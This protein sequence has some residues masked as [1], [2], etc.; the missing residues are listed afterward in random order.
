MTRNTA[1]FI[2]L[3]I[4]FFIT[5]AFSEEAPATGGV[6]AASGTFSL[7]GKKISIEDAVKL[8]LQNNKDLLDARYDAKMADSQYQK[9][10]SK[11][12]I[13]LGAQGELTYQKYPDLLSPQTG[14]SQTVTDGTVSIAKNFSTGTTLAGGMKQSMTQTDYT[15]NPLHLPVLSSTGVDSGNYVPYSLGYDKYFQP[16]MFVQVQQELLKNSFGYSDRQQEKILQN[17][18]KLQRRAQLARVSGLVA[19]A[20][21]DIWNV[22][23]KKTAL[24]NSSV[25]LKETKKVRDIVAAN[26]RLGISETFDL[27]LYNAMY[28]GSEARYAFAEQ[29][30]RD[31][32]RKLYRT[33]NVEADDSKQ[34]VT[35][36]LT[37][38]STLQDISV[39]AALKA[40]YAKRVDY[41][42]ALMEEENSKMDLGIA[43][44]GELPSLTAGASATYYSYEEKFGKA[45][46]NMLSLKTPNYG[47]N[48]KMSYPLFDT[49]T[50]VTV[51]DAEYK[52]QQSK[53]RLDKIRRAVKDDII[54]KAEQV[55][56]VFTGYQKAKLAREES[57]RYFYSIQNYLRM[58]KVTSAV[59]KNA[60]DSLTS[61]RQSELEALVAYNLTLVQMDLATNELLEKYNVNT[62]QYLSEVK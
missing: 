10:L 1:L 40:A 20:L 31:A 30:Y 56:V 12:S 48:V 38:S 4:V 2:F 45:N 18:T 5:P 51:R 62:E 25:S 60:L 61:S 24:D 58:G 9:F 50:A 27:N 36:V 42:S 43:R 15:T 23:L 32:V 41:A 3:S 17:V 13:Y 7:N 28:A 39:E 59:V 19:G 54:S 35:D 53:L 57:E 22:T 44:N 47:V 14:T 46:S 52:V 26:A 11:Y 49:G 16:A 29:D 33:L 21:S 8:V 55:R 6:T 37:L 34:P